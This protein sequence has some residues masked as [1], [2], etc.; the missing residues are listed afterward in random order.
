M[1]FFIVE[2]KT[3]RGLVICSSHQ[4]IL[5]QFLAQEDLLEKG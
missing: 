4:E 2:I 1:Y 3:E 5:A